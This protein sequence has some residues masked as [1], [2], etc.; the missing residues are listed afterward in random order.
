MSCTLGAEGEDRFDNKMQ[1]GLGWVSWR[2]WLSLAVFALQNGLAVLIMRWSKIR[3]PE[4]YSSQVA[5][6]MQEFAGKL[7]V[8]LVLYS[9]ECGGFVAALR[10]M[11]ADLRERPKEWL[12]LGVPA[13]LYTIQNTCLFIGYGHVEPAVGQIVYQSKLLWVALF[14]LCLL[15]KRLTSTQWLALFVLALG[16][17]AVQTVD[18]KPRP[19]A[20]LAPAMEQGPA[21]PI[22]AASGPGLGKVHHTPGGHSDHK[23]G[24]YLYA[25]HPHEHKAT[26]MARSSLASSG[27]LPLVEAAPPAPQPEHGAAA[28]QNPMLGIAS[29]ILAAVCT[30]FASVYFEKMIKS[31]SQPSL[32]LRN[33]QLA[34]YSSAIAVVGL[35]LSPD[36]TLKEKGW[37]AGFTANTW[38][39]VLWQALGGIIVA[40][41]IKH[42]DNIL[43]GFANALA[44]IIGAFG[45]YLLFDFHL[46]FGFICGCAFV[47]AAIF[48]YG[49]GPTSPTEL[50]EH[51]ARALGCALLWQKVPADELSKELPT[52]GEDIDEAALKRLES[53][54]RGS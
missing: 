23:H 35:L 47:I 42:A 32:W 1:G 51:S 2:G 46:S 12:Q 27:S 7:P 39:C 6:L 36:A 18:S 53:A 5:V 24:R 49:A 28:A 30:A 31:A 33:I 54:D 37:M 40:V 8:C 19:P 48:L 26:A 45:S 50:C 22:R 38:F 41:T 20:A 14:S 21:P 10:R 44:L 17:V 4:P 29:L 3:Q 34:L 15:G 13:L 52:S 16:V 25:T 11:A 9:F 43:R